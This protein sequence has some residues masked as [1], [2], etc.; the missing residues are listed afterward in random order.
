[1]ITFKN[2]VFVSTFGYENKH[3]PKQAGF[4]FHGA[5]SRCQQPGSKPCGACKADLGLNVWWTPFPEK[6]ALVLDHCDDAAKTAL[7][8]HLS[9]VAASRAADADIEVPAPSGLEYLPYQLA[10]IAYALTRKGVLFADEMG[11]GKTIESIGVINVDEKVRSILVLCPAGLRLNWLRELHKWLV[12]PFHF[13]VVDNNKP[14]PTTATCVIANYD[15]LKGDVL[16]SLMGRDFDCMIVDEAHYLKNG[17]A[18][19]TK[20]VLGV[21]PKWRK[22]GGKWEQTKPRV[23]GLIDQINYRVMF[24]T[25]TPILNRPIEAWTLIRACDPNS[26]GKSRSRYAKTYCNAHHNGYGYDESGCNKDKMPEL[27]ERLRMGFM[28]RRLKKDVLKELPA[29]RRQVV[30]VPPNGATKAVRE[31]QEAFAAR[32]ERLQ[33]LRSLLELAHASGDDAAYKEALENLRKGMQVA[34]E[35]ISAARKRVAIAKV[36]KVI[37]HLD[38]MQESGINK[39]VVFAH[40]HEVIDQI[41]ANFGDDAV[42][43]DGRV[44]DPVVRDAYVERFQTD[45]T[46]KVFI[47]G[48]RAAGVG[49]TLTAACHV[50]FAELDWTPAMMSQC[51]DRTHRVGQTESVLVQHIV[52]DGSLDANMAEQLVGKQAICDA[53]LDTEGGLKMP[54][55]PNAPKR[56]AKYPVPTDEERKA[57]GEA[58]RFLSLRCDG[59]VT[60]DGRGFNKLDTNMGKQLGFRS[61]RR[62][63]TDGEVFLSKRL[64]RT[65]RRQL[66]QELRDALKTDEP[67]AKQLTDLIRSFNKN[68]KLGEGEVLLAKKLARTQRDKMPEALLEAIGQSGFVQ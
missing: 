64:A 45:P 14:V 50:V 19:R 36:P 16:N 48:I 38:L 53:G 35:E 33:E 24:L 15:R 60:E 44:N 7:K 11:L 29:K 13:Y 61:Q 58:M 66:P 40:H 47:G 5:R 6:A 65:Y 26:L 62:P 32:E 18:Q 39:I 63:L 56:P 20:K 2:G 27:Q 52:L 4:W 1:M 68:G 37:E 30:V 51:E 23:P 22:A 34:F 46:C 28:V 67:T 9:T 42:V 43:V 10:G 25:G 57:A 31:E 49:I 8:D 21:D 54:A 41:R 17:K 12:R 59:A 3:I 55:V